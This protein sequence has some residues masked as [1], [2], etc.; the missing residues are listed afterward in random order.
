MLPLT[1]LYPQSKPVTLGTRIFQVGEMRVSDMVAIQDWLED[2]WTSPLEGL[3]ASRSDLEGPGR[4]KVLLGIWDA[5]E[6]GPPLFGSERANQYLDTE[7]GALKV[8]EVVLRN[9]HPELDGFQI[10]A[11]RESMTQGQYSALLAAWRRPDATYEVARELGFLPQELEHGPAIGW[12]ELIAEV[13]AEYGWTLDYVY[14]LSLSQIR[15]LRRGG[16][17]IEY[18]TPVRPKTTLKETM[19]ARRKQIEALEGG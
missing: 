10:A 7:A 8:L 12:P 5:L 3:G 9:H 14:G 15:T 2:H 19:M 16:K 6:E 4:A 13:C 18:G 1:R 17:P 11:I